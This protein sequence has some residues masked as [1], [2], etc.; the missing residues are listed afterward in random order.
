[1]KLKIQSSQENLNQLFLNLKT[2]QDVAT[3]LEISFNTLVYHIYKIDPQNRYKTFSIPKKSGQTRNISAPITNLKIIQ[4][5]LQYILQQVYLPRSVV[6][7]FVPDRD[8]VSNA[9]IHCKK[10]Y[11][12]N[13]DLLD[14]FPSINFGRVRGMFIKP[15]YN[16]PPAV[17]T[18]LA[19]ICCYNNEL[20]QGAPTSPIISNMICARMDGELQRI[21][22]KYRCD[23]SRYADDITFSTSNKSFP[24]NLCSSLNNVDIIGRELESIIHSNGF[25]INTNKVRLQHTAN[26]QSVTGLITNIFPNTKKKFIKQIRSMLYD[27]DRYGLMKAQNKLTT[28]YH[29]PAPFKNVLRGKI[30]FLGM[31]RG[32][33]D[34]IYQKYLMAFNKLDPN[35]IPSTAGAAFVPMA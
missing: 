10:N 27:W 30:E 7:G 16:L 13:I 3:L 28:K 14:F 1:M 4:K 25:Q 29:N 35:F 6:H 19:Q 15:P 12:L 23:Y 33:N 31:V 11:V 9:Q 34:A 8:I 20:P 32:K 5:K 18:I 26:R 17:A 21:A 24:N 2:P 22:G